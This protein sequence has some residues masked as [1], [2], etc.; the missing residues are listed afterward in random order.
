MLAV[1]LLLAAATG[2]AR[3]DAMV[4]AATA[5]PPGTGGEITVCGRRGEDERSPYLSPLPREYEVGDPR[6]QSVSAERN[7]LFD[8]DAGGS[9]SCSAVG[10][11]GNMGCG[12]QRHK[13]WVL[14][15]AGAADG[16]GPLFAK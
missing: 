9:G 1:A 2:T 7:G 15:K 16:R 4:K 13:R 10:L 11:T 12:F 5:C 14:Q 3:L 8:Y 6:A